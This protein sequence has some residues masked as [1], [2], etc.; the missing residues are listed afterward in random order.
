MTE[1]KLPDEDLMTLARNGNLDAVGVLFERYH[2]RLF[3]FFLNLTRCRELSS[4]LTQTVFYR[5]MKYRDTYN[6]P[7]TFK[8]WMYRIA[9]NAFTDHYRTRKR[10]M[11]NE[12]GELKLALYNELSDEAEKEKKEKYEALSAAMDKLP[13]KQKEI[14]LL[15]RFEGLKYN[16][17]SE[18]TGD[19]VANVKVTA[20]RAIKSLKKL[21]FENV[22]E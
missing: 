12:N 1:V 16:E 2:A 4:D 17:I 14:I 6:G 22:R 10:R 11:E 9:R 8:T 3:N 18:I 21:Y 7:N 15:S 5:I 20:H 19:S 13:G